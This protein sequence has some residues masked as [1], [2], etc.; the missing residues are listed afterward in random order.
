MG[1][2]GLGKSKSV[3]TNSQPI[4]SATD[5]KKDTRAAKG[6]LLETEGENKGAELQAGQGRSVRRVFGG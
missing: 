1:F 4:A 3:N 6:R 5:E 2:F